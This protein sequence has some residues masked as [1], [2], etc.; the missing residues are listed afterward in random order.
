MFEIDF[1]VQEALLV[2]RVYLDVLAILD[3]LAIQAQK[4]KLVHQELMAYLAS[5]VQMARKGSKG[6]VGDQ[7]YQ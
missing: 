7:D 6:A 2:T 4:G 1:K 3:Y 5:M